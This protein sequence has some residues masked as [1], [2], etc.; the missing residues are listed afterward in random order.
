MGDLLQLPSAPKR[1]P[2]PVGTV[3]EPFGK[4]IAV[5]EHY[6]WFLTK[7]GLSL[8]PTSVIEGK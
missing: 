6:Y 3:L 5:G 7:Q 1:T 4:V 8:V 2:L